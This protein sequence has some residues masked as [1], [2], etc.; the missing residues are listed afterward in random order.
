MMPAIDV[1]KNIKKEIIE[2]SYKNKLGH[3]GSALSM[4]DMLYHFFSEHYV[5][6]IE[7]RDD[8]LVIG[9][10]Y[11]SQA[12]HVVMR[13]FN[14]DPPDPSVSGMQTVS[15]GIHFVE[16]TLGNAIGYASG[17]AYAQKDKKVIHVIAG[18]AALTQGA[19]WEAIQLASKFKLNNLH[20]VVD[21]NRMG[22]LGY[23][24]TLERLNMKF[25]AF[26]W[27]CAYWNS[28]LKE[29]IHKKPSVS[30]YQTTKGDGISFMENNPE[31]HYKKLD[32][33]HYLKAMEELE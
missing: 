23:D 17:L 16:P 33:E 5:P 3:I 10:P 31:W 2:L 15:E 1:S 12:L 20:L 7:E 19:S 29:R 4:S 32:R 9:K 22:I 26:G 27:H 28:Y 25:T 13:H 14:F 18:D 8:M 21:N 24:S 6:G 30:F 11:G